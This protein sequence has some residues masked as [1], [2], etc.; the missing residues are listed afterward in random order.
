MGVCKDGLF[1]IFFI[2]TLNR[3]TLDSKFDFGYFLKWCLERMGVRPNFYWF[4]RYLTESVSIW[5]NLLLLKLSQ[6]RPSDFS[7]NTLI[8]DPVKLWKYLT[9]QSGTKVSALAKTG[10]RGICAK[11]LDLKYTN[12]KWRNYQGENCKRWNLEYKIWFKWLI[13]SAEY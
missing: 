7:C 13:F 10:Q 12:K 9:L 11:N 8:N 4:R 2:E 3:T 6:I 5:K 1:R